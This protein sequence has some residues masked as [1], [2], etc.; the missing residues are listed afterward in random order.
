MQRP[1]T[2]YYSITLPL[3]CTIMNE[4]VKMIKG[5]YSCFMML[6]GLVTI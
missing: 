5:G 6:L 1:D 3:E 4:R 2:V